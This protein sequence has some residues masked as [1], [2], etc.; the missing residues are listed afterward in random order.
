MSNNRIL[1]TIVIAFSFIIWAILPFDPYLFVADSISERFMKFLF[2]LPYDRKLEQE[3]D[4]V[5]TMLAA[6]V[7]LKKI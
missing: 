6:K 3:A 2:E 1:E 7:I 5:G 4:Y